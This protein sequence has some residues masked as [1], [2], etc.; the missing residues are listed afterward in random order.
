MLKPY[1]FMLLAIVGHLASAQTP[2]MQITEGNM[3]Q[4]PCANPCVTLH[5]QFPK[6]KKT[7]TYSV[8]NIPFSTSIFTGTNIAFA[9]DDYFSSAI[10]IGFDFCFYGNTYSQVYVSDNGHLTFN[11]LYN[12][13][14]SSFAT[15]TALPFFNGAYPDNAIFGPFLDAK[16]SL[17]GS[18]KYGI[19]GSAPFRTFMVEYNAI[20]F[21]NNNCTGSTNN[22][23]QIKLFETHNR[24]E[25]HIANKAVCNTLSTNWLN[26]ATLGIQSIAASNYITAPNKNASIWTSSNTAFEFAPNGSI[27]YSIKW[28]NKGS[29]VPVGVGVD[30]LVTCLGTIN[31]TIYATYTTNCP[32]QTISDTI[33]LF[34]D[35]PKIDSLQIIQPL[36]TGVNNGCVTIFANS[37][38]SPLT[39]K[40]TV[41][42]VIGYQ[43][44]NQFCNL[45]SGG[46]QFSIKDA[47]GCIKDTFLQLA[48]IYT[49]TVN[50]LFITPDTCPLNIGAVAVAAVN[51]VG[52]YNYLW[53]TNDNDS[54]LNNVK[55]NKTYGVVVKDANNCTTATSFYVP[56]KGLPQFTANITKATCGKPN[57]QINIITTGPGAPFTYTSLPNAGNTATMTGVAPNT[58]LI[59]VTSSLGCDTEGYVQVLDTLNMTVGTTVLNTTCNL[60]NGAI[61]LAL[62]KGLPPYAITINGVP[63]ASISVNNLTSGNYSITVSDSNNCIKSDTVWVDSSKGVKLLLLPANAHCDSSN[64][65]IGCVVQSDTLPITY[66]W[67]NNN[68]TDYINGLTTGNY[69]LKATNPIGCYVTDTVAIADDG[70]PTLGVL[71]YT[72]ALCF[73]DST[74]QITLTGYFGIPPYKY[75]IDSTN[76]SAV[77]VVNNIVGGLYHIYIKDAASCIRDTIINLAFPDSITLTHS[78]IDSLVCY[79]DVKDSITLNVNGLNP[80]FTI[81][82]NGQILNDSLITNVP[83]GNNQIVVTD[84]IGCKRNFDILVPVP[85]AAL[86]VDEKITP[87]PCFTKNTG[88]IELNINGGWSPY[89]VTWAD[90]NYNSVIRDQLAPTTLTYEVIDRLGCKTSDTALIKELQCCVVVVPNAFS[91]NGDNINETLIP[92]PISDIDYFVF[93][94]YNRWGQQVFE[95]DNIKKEWNGGQVNDTH[96]IETYYYTLRYKCIFGNEYFLQKGDINVIR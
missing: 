53:N 7:N 73:G 21:F 17:G 1:F 90:T 35:I 92:I 83:G 56:A 38:T 10:P 58:Y 3:L 65:A 9:S 20:P 89:Q 40:M 59:K 82:Y 13:Q 48:A 29:I 12:G 26:Y 4:L 77:A 14:P 84:K 8:N 37:T 16:L 93:K 27:D 5:A 88:S 78:N 76:F 11:S 79:A 49:I 23:F 52:P 70:V 69:W 61:S 62:N 96:E 18:V 43:S 86:E 32:L 72:P 66:L 28:F 71:S 31:N 25:C 51:G 30:S 87:L 68:A 85:E 80:P 44:S 75:S 2:L 55:G 91:P 54:L 94:I 46:Y 42:Q 67:S 47:A 24:V 15:Q 50:K 41:P 6:V 45:A 95:T 19:I 33:V 81:M 36:C 22:T 39:Y 64:G 57:G 60:S 63:S 74:G 34:K